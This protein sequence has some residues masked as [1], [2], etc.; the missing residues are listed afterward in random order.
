MQIAAAPAL[1]EALEH[2]LRKVRGENIMG[3][4]AACGSEIKGEHTQ[5]CVV[6]KAEAALAL[7]DGKEGG[8]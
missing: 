2:T 8:A 6:V 4:C 1:Y 5:K 7:A 3:G